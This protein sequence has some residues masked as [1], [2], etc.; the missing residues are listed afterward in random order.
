MAQRAAKGK[1]VSYD[2]ELYMGRA[3]SF[4]KPPETTTG[5]IL[6]DGPDTVQDEDIPRSFLPLIGTRRWLYRI[7]LEGV[8]GTDERFAVDR[9][10]RRALATSKGVLFDLQSGTFETVNK[11]GAVAPDTS[12]QPSLGSMSF[13]FTDGEAFYQHGFA[14]MLETVAEL[15]PAAMPTRYGTYEPLQGKVF[16]GNYAEIVSA[17][18]DDPGGLFLKSPTP[19]GHVFL[20]VPCKKTFELYHPKHFIRRH[21]LLGKVEFELRPAVF[22]NLGNRDAIMALFKALCA[23]LGIVYAEILESESLKGSWFWYGL[24]DRQNA[25][26]ICIGPEYQR[27]WPEAAVGGEVIGDGLRVFTSDRFGTKPPRPPAELLVP[28]QSFDPQGKPVCARVFPFDYEFDYDKY[29]W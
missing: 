9:W 5:N 1:V 8:F 19:F 26:S 20:S 28:D 23:E 11:S 2:F 12:A 22:S 6:C 13:Y 21:H 27:V 16:P 18:H 10:L 17:F 29:R 15:L 3:T 7:H 14:A 25:H 4:E 24:P